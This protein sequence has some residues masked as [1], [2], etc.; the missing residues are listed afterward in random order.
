MLNICHFLAFQFSPAQLVLLCWNFIKCLAAQF[1][2]QS[3][4][5]WFL[6]ACRSAFSTKD[7]SRCYGLYPTDLYSIEVLQCQNIFFENYILDYGNRGYMDFFPPFFLL[8]FI[9]HFIKGLVREIFLSCGQL[10]PCLCF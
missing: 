10:Q 9:F 7:T 5:C 2:L 6:N 3:S 1:D 4:L 8:H